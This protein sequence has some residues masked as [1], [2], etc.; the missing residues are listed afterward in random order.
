MKEIEMEIKQDEL[1]QNKILNARSVSQIQT[2][3]N[4]LYTE[5]ATNSLDLDSLLAT[6]I[7]LLQETI[8]IEENVREAV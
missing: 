5:A 3:L 7:N 1:I 2:D 8:G 6:S 4:A